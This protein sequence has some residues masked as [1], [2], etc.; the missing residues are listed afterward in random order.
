MTAWCM[1]HL[2][3]LPRTTMARD[4]SARL[5]RC[6]YTREIEPEKYLTLLYLG[7]DSEGRRKYFKR[8]THAIAEAEAADREAEEIKRTGSWQTEAERTPKQ[9]WPISLWAEQFVSSETGEGTVPRPGTQEERA[10][11]LR[12]FVQTVGD[13]P[14]RQVDRSHF[15]QF[16]ERYEVKGREFETWK[17]ALSMVRR[18][19]THAQAAGALREHPFDAQPQEWQDAM[20]RRT[21][22]RTSHLPLAA[23]ADGPV[24]RARTAVAA[25]SLDAAELELLC[26]TALDG[27]ELARQ[28]PRSHWWIVRAMAFGALTG[29]RPQELLAL[30]ESEIDLDDSEEA[31]DVGVFWAIKWAEEPHDDTW[32]A[33]GKVWEVSD[34][35]KT[36]ASPRTVRAGRMA[37]RVLM[38][39]LACRERIVGP[40]LFSCFR[41]PTIPA[42]FRSRVGVVVR[43][44]GLNPSH[45]PVGLRHTYATLALSRGVP[46]HVVSKDL[47]HK[48][49]SMTLDHYVDYLPQH[50]AASASAFDQM[51][52]E[53]A[54]TRPIP[55]HVAGSG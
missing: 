9:D 2:I 8:T 20:Y 11:Y 25:T 52:T 42:A 46:I 18:M 21:I 26:R 5:P 45:T 13:L 53:I 50:R 16:R 44:L 40:T 12:V 38:A 55:L 30:P 3:P 24:Q 37:Y 29:T 1:S 35:M 54:A 49:V 31:L 32:E 34:L 27:E 14:I 47:G 4:N 36:E 15:E 19:L 10:S 6:R 41:T 7:R 33:H 22:R 17:S 43:R 28:I 51:L 48:K 23:D 39:H